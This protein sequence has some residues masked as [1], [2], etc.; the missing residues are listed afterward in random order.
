MSSSKKSQRTPLEEFLFNNTHSRES[1]VN[2]RLLFDLKLAAAKKAY[3][4]NAYVPEVDQN[5]FDV[6]FDDQDSLAKVQLKTVM[7][8]AQTN[9]WP[10]HRGLIRPTIDRHHEFGFEASPVGCGYEGG[11]IL[12]KI[13]V[14][15]EFSIKYFLYRHNDSVCISR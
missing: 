3:F 13:K 1:L 10:I 7:E 9:C 8:G 4:L 6:I 11:I 5:G 15:P 14:A 12:M 2:N